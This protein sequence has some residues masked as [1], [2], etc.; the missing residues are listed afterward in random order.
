MM[1]H[2]NHSRDIILYDLL[3]IVAFTLLGLIALCAAI[4]RGAAHHYIS[5]LACVFL[6]WTAAHELKRINRKINPK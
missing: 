5:A 6:V 3:V 4:F 2:N 1:N